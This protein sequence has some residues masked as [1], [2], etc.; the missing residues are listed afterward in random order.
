MGEQHCKLRVLRT[1]SPHKPLAISL[2][3]VDQFMLSSSWDA[4]IVEHLAAAAREVKSAAFLDDSG[5]EE[6]IDRDFYRR[7]NLRIVTDI[8]IVGPRTLVTA[9]A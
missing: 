7:Y 3:V 8:A 9:G 6:G 5:D 4:A 1:P 2:P